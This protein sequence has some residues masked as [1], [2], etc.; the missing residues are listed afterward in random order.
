VT[1]ARVDLGAKDLY[2]PEQAEQRM[3]EHAAHYAALVEQLASEY[4]TSSGGYG[5]ISSNY[6]AEL[7]GHWW[8]EGIAWLREV[9][10]TLAGSS[11]VDLTT[12]SGFV[13]EHEPQEMM[14]VPESSWGSGGNHWTWDNEATHWMW[15]PIHAAENAMERL[16]ERY[17]EASG[18]ILKAL[19][20]AA[21]E[22]L[23][24]ESSDWPFLV[25]TGQAK[26]YAAQRFQSHVSRFQQ[27]VAFLERGAVDDAAALADALY[28]LDKLFPT[29]DYRWFGARQGI[30]R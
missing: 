1:G 16:V 2:Y 25:T 3:R 4:H 13:A 17:P 9:L 23:L 5:I 28:E 11:V 27:L 8:F 29:I 30:A 15:Q 6:D 14:A 10:R 7:F 24:L 26:E 20:Q 22:L 18:G 21:R 19:N 12:T